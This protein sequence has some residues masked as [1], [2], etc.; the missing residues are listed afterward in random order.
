[1]DNYENIEN[2][3][4]KGIIFGTFGTGSVGGFVQ[5]NSGLINNSYSEVNVSGGTNVGGFV[6]QNLATGEISLSQAYSDVN[7]SDRVGG[8]V[9]FNAKGGVI[10]SCFSQGNVIFILPS[11]S[12]GGGFVGE[13]GGQ[14]EN[15][16]SRGNIIRSKGTNTYFAGFCGYS[17]SYSTVFKSYSTGNVKYTNGTNPIDKGFFAYG[18]PDDSRNNFWDKNS[19]QQEYSYG[20]YLGWVAGKTTSQMKT[21]GT[22]TSW[23]F[24]TVWAIDS[25]GNINNGYPYLINNPP[26]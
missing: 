16:Y 26:Q 18:T 13:N 10:N 12:K 2:S 7:G 23:D 17:Q 24:S 11:Q 22:F 3:Y 14:I 9:G 8:F 20:D 6:A 1:M 5:N 19:S 15:C 25:S 21:Q 4:S